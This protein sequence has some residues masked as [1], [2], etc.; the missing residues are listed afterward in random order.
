MNR[1]VDGAWPLP[2]Q[3]PSWPD[4]ADKALT[5]P[6]A[7]SSSGNIAAELGRLSRGSTPERSESSAASRGSP[8]KG[9]GAPLLATGLEQQ[10]ASKV[11]RPDSADSV[12]APTAALPTE[13]PLLGSAA[14]PAPPSQFEDRPTTPG[15]PRL[16]RAEAARAQAAAEAAAAEERARRAIQERER[17][18]ALAAEEEKVR[19]AA[20]LLARET[21]A[22]AERLA[23]AAAAVAEAEAAAVMERAIAAESKPAA[24]A[25]ARSLPPAAAADS[26]VADVPSAP[27]A[28]QS[29]STAESGVGSS[30]PGVASQGGGGGSLEA[31]SQPVTAADAFE[32]SEK[33]LAAAEEAARV[34]EEEE[35]RR[36]AEEEAYKQVKDT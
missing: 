13:A 14:A 6:P 2:S 34:V 27:E 21:A 25:A 32:A 9:T 19:V 4:A 5:R 36:L 11:A 23:M 31:E 7:S 18:L 30:I 3:P 15:K 16:K 10:A 35:A 1:P 26:A 20:E 24:L 17:L 33:S 22:E 28:E 12:V 29:D 8:G